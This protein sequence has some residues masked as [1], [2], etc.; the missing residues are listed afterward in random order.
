MSPSG[1]TPPLLGAS[2]HQTQA[3][4]TLSPDIATQG[5][6]ARSPHP[7]FEGAPPSSRSSL[8]FDFRWSGVG[9]GARLPLLYFFDRG[10][11]EW[12]DACADAWTRILDFTAANSVDA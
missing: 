10:F 3:R 4:R 5:P 1:G 7:P 6:S 12:R 8:L 9:C 11:A 2:K